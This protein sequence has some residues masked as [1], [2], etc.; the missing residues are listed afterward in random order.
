MRIHIKGGRLVD[1][2]H[3][4]DGQRDLFL[5]DG[6]V[7]AVGRAPAGF[8]AEQVIDATGLVVCPGLVDLAARLREPG[9]EYKATLQSELAAAV[10]GGVTSLAC[11][12]DTDPPL[13]E[14]GL[15][16]ML[17]HR[18]RRL[19]LAHVY[20][21]GALTQQLRG[22]RLTEMAELTDAGC[23]GFSQAD[24]PLT[25]TL[26][27]YR[28]L[29]YASTFGY[30]VWL[31]PEDPHLAQSGVAHD[32]EVASRL[33]LPPIPAVS[34]PLE[35]ARILTLARET[36]AR[37]H[38][39]RVSQADSLALV[40]AAKAEGLPVTCDVSINHL[41]LSVMDI[42]YFDSNCRLTPPLRDRRDRDALREALKGGVIDALCSDH[43]PVDDDAKQLPFGEAQPGAVGL[44]LLLPLA[45]KWGEA[46]GVPLAQVIARV[47]ADPARVLG[48]EAGHLAPGMPADVCIFDPAAAWRVTP[49]ELKSQGRNTPFA[50][51][52]M[53]AR[54]RFT[55]VDGSIVHAA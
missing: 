55:L 49:V 43:A 34:E 54:V 22:E 27:F 5:A 20:P 37:V 15:V 6:R 10:A 46:A 14:P 23:V 4:V 26:V 31:R 48:I 1:P 35:V 9:F 36:G 2:R 16:E 19:R 21:V 11:P 53:P 18:A 28:A 3:G 30:A 12:P 7:A 13:D 44:E 39:C 45:L 50:G 8:S 29:Q 25:N 33:G 40:A 41:H 52:E 32:S 51:Y 38:L 17:R 24:A 42:G 47:T